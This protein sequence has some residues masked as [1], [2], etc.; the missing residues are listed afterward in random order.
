MHLKQ[1]VGTTDRII[2]AIVGI[3]FLVLG[4]FILKGIWAG[5]LLVFGTALVVS[6]ALGFCPTYL[7]F[8]FSTKGV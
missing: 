5:I 4:L 6:A 7:P 8:H 3:I 1:N 2:R